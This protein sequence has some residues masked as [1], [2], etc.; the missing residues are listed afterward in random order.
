GNNHL[1]IFDQVTPNPQL[2]ELDDVSL[3]FKTKKI[4]K[5]VALGGGSVI[6]AAKVL[7]LCIPSSSNKVL[8]KLFR[9]NEKI[10]WNMAIDIIAIPT[11]AGTGSEV[12]PFATV[13]D[14]S[15]KKKFSLNSNFIFPKFALLI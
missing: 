13:W 4:H 12:T 14:N 11:T 9:Q 8:N 15:T 2:D 1:F 6:D 10:L 5:I 3:K 7:S